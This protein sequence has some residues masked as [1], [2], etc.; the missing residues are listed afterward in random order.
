MHSVFITLLL[1]FGMTSC[2]T[3][4]SFKTAGGQTIRV[5]VVKSEADKTKGLSGRA[6]KDFG[7]DQAMLFWY[8]DIGA[9]R[10]WMPN[11]YFDLDIFFL[12]KDFVILDVDR[13][14]AHYPQ[15]PAQT[16][17]YAAVPTT[18]TVIAQ[19][20][21]EMR[22]S[23]PFSKGLQLGQKLDWIKAP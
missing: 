17:N 20:V 10:F 21:L 14:V 8:D 9:R 6:S 5:E 1:A 3:K 4:P 7:D 11:T 13:N 19:H 15:D 18:R 2:Q 23:S 12:D 22:A 16:G